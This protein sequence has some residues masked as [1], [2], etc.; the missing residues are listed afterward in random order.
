MSYVIADRNY[1]I[2]NIM[3]TYLSNNYI[4]IIFLSKKEILKNKHLNKEIFILGDIDY[5]IYIYKN[6]HNCNPIIEDYPISIKEFLNR[7]IEVMTYEDAKK[8]SFE[9]RI[10]IKPILCK[11]FDINQNRKQV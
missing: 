7:N 4:E 9:K 10:F 5:V 6:L 3:L 8:L 1:K 2:S 11:K